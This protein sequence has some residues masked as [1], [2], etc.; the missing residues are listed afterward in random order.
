M[1]IHR[2]TA[3]ARVSR[4][5]TATHALTF[6][7]IYTHH[8]HS[9]QLR[10]LAGTGNTAQSVQLG[11]AVEAGDLQITLPTKNPSRIPESA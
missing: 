5:V 4:G 6:T 10:P 7:C 2:S 11:L 1:V 3:A 9:L 8:T